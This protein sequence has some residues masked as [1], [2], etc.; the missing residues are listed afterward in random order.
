MRITPRALVFLLVVGA[1]AACSGG[2]SR[3]AASAPA[4]PAPS[5]APSA[6]AN[7]GPGGSSNGAASGAV[8]AGREVPRP[9]D[10]PQRVRIA[11]AGLAAQG[12]TYLAVEHGYFR[13]LGLDVEVM[14]GLATN[15]MVT[16]LS[17][18]QLDVGLQAISPAFYNV[19]ARGVGIRLVADHGSLIPGRTTVSL[20]VRTDIL[21]RKPWTG[22][23]DL[24]GL[25][26]GSNQAGSLGTYYRQLILQRG[27]LTDA[28]IDLVEPLPFPDMAVAFANKAIDAGQ[29]NEP[30]ATMQEEQGIVK[31]VMYMDAIEPY[32]HIAGLL[33]GEAFARNTAAARNYMV[34]YLRGIRHYWDAYDGRR[35]FQ[36]VV[37]VLKKYTQL[38]DENVIRKV[39]QTGQNPN[40]YLDPARVAFYQDWFH[41]QGLVPQKVD[42]ARAL[43]HSFLD[44]ANA[45]LGPYEP[46]PNAR[47][48]P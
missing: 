7:A 43:D 14:S 24:K 40:G 37:D 23:A 32:G 15:D 22:P 42:I 26:V 6:P 39:P 19:V 5:A 45:V 9:L 8:I 48:A 10:P 44:Y 28:D 13:E 4:A 1:L 31:K 46:V 34:G 41:E 38:K 35:D 25:R 18:D 20:A 47:G 12:P 21:E 30:W 16:L 33:Y 11:D 3:P 17:S 27:G 29:Y 36:D 2:T